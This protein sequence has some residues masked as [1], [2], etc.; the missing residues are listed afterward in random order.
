MRSPAHKAV[1]LGDA[2][3][4]KTALIHI[5][6]IGEMGGEASTIQPSEVI[7][8]EDVDGKNVTVAMWDTPGQ[9]NFRNMVK[10]F[11]RD[12]ECI[13]LVYDVTKSET[14]YNLDEW[15]KFIQETIEI[16]NLIVVGNKID[17]PEREI[18]RV[19]GNNWAMKH[20]G[21]YFETSALTKE[22]VDALFGEV[23]RVVLD[24]VPRENDVV[25]IT[26]IGKKPKSNKCC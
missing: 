12:S 7:Y 20:R 22:G 6:E 9:Y 19:T 18:N 24:D 14:F 17:L 13:V 3:V 25:T 2:S 23:A 26:N 16:R 21:I 11:L 5:R 4:G 10:H 15:I 1:I 8:N